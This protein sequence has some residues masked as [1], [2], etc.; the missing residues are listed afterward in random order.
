[1]RGR[2]RGLWSA[3]SCKLGQAFRPSG[4]GWGG[5][6]RTGPGWGEVTGELMSGF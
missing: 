6:D 2:G 4:Q 3:A 1:V 5:H